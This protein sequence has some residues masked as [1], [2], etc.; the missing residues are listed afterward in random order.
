MYYVCS[1]YYLC[2]KQQNVHCTIKQKNLK[3]RTQ[4]LNNPNIC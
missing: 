2:G 1:C 4:V 3:S